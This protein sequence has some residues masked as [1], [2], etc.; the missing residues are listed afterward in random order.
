MGWVANFLNRAM[1]IQENILY[2]FPEEKRKAGY[3]RSAQ[4]I[5]DGP[6]GGEFALWF[7]E[8]GV[9]PKPEGVEIK[10]QVYMTEE[11]L[12]DLITPDVTL[13]RLV[14]TIE[15]EGLDN[16]VPHFY[17]RLN[18]RT[19]LANGL[20]TIGGDTSDIDSEEWSRILEN[21]LLRIAFPIVIKGL[22]KK[23]KKRGA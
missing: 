19:A 2:D 18:F 3:G 4:L 11:T 14:A 8:Q 16:A 5:I 6:G 23:T 22:L 1:A 13:D 9:K 10:N 7:C 12:L 17:P 20:V 15:K 21:V